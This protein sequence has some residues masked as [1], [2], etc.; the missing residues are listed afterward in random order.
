MLNRRYLLCLSTLL[1]QGTAVVAQQGYYSQICPAQTVIELVEVYNA[2]ADQTEYR[3]Q[4]SSL[5]ENKTQLFKKCHCTGQVFHNDFVCPY[6]TNLCAI[7]VSVQDTILCFEEDASTVLVRNI[8]PLV[9]LWYVFL[10]L[11][12]FSY[13]GRHAITYCIQRCFPSTNQILVNRIMEHHQTIRQHY[14][15]FWNTNQ[16]QN[17]QEE[18]REL[19]LKTKKFES[20][21]TIDEGELQEEEEEEGDDPSMCCTICFVPMEQGDRIGD[22]PCQHV[23]HVECLKG[24]VKRKNTCPLCAIPL[25]TQRKESS[26]Q[27]TQNETTENTP[28]PAENNV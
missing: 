3:Y 5:G 10:C 16:E 27:T 18:C 21:P 25:A 13:K 9:C 1:F 28:E 17:E 23:F 14:F 15:N 11:L 26:Q 24:W 12:C 7:P 2:T 4:E 19:V 8:W 22:L 6:H 20:P